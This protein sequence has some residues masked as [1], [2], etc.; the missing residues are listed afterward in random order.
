MTRT[1]LPW[2]ET[3]TDSAYALGAAARE[4]RTAH[5][6]A[7]AAV[8][9]YDLDRVR[10]LDGEITVPGLFTAPRPHDRAVMGIGKALQECQDRME[11]LHTDAALSYAYG[12][13]W[14]ILRVLNGQEPPRIE[15]GLTAEG[16]LIIPAELAPIPP[17]IEG[18]ERWCDNAK[19]DK[20]RQRWWE[21]NSAGEYASAVAD[22]DYLA[23]HEAN[24]MHQALDVAQ[25]EADAAYAYGV[26]A[27]S[28]LHYALLG[29][30]A[31]HNRP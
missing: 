20:A 16:C 26:L 19:F 17:A 10:L 24:E 25:G 27:E 12:T 28:A 18:L 1:T 31:R 22:Q 14:A 6:A 23:D 21:C 7:Q 5:Q 4:T 11:R 3:L 15:L 29:P 13:A 8:A 30:C 2:F 9:Q